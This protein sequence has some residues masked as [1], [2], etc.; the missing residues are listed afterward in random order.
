MKKIFTLISMICLC[1]FNAMAANYVLDKEL[2][3]DD[4]KGGE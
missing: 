1:A 3:W 2:S 4:V